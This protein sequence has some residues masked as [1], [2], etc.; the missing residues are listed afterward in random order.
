MQTLPSNSTKICLPDQ[1]TQLNLSQ[2]RVLELSAT[3][4]SLWQQ[5][6]NFYDKLLDRLR[7]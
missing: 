6:E 2:F 5:N 3:E 7:E 1:K 4:L